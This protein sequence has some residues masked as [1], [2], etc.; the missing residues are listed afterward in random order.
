M[1]TLS[2]IIPTYN[3]SAYI[4]QALN[5]LLIDR[6]HELDILVIN[7]GSKDDSSEKAKKIAAQYPDS[8]RVI[9]KKNGN[10]GSCINQGLREAKGKYVKIFDA[11]DSFNT[12]E[13]SIYVDLL[14]KQN[15]DIVINDYCEVDNTNVIRQSYHFNE[16]PKNKELLLNNLIHRFP[17]ERI[18]MHAVAFKRDLLYK[19]QY[20]QTEGISYTDDEWIFSPFGFS[21]TIFNTGLMVYR[22]LVG[23]EGQTIEICTL[24]RRI[25]QLYKVIKNCTD[26]MTN[27]KSV[28]TPFGYNYFIKRLDRG[29]T[30]LYS[31]YLFGGNKYA[32]FDP[33]SLAH[34]LSTSLPCVYQLLAAKEISLARII[35]VR[36]IEEYRLKGSHSF[37]LRLLRAWLKLASLKKKQ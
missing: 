25:D 3:M 24:N 12:D 11:D 35:Y 6:I 10:Y 9:D 16:I 29:Y 28:I 15:C 36:Y 26:F 13:L 31:R 21:E 5:S 18:A 34:E 19:I 8:I 37:R 2:I 1:K 33:Q 22:Y 27:N 32:S 23:R 20:R 7:D 14:K 30:I 4:E 17:A